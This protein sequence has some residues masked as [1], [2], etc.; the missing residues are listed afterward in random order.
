MKKTIRLHYEVRYL[1]NQLKKLSQQIKESTELEKGL[2]EAFEGNFVAIFSEIAHELKVLRL[3]LVL[4]LLANMDNANKR[5]AFL[6]MVEFIQ[7]EDLF[8]EFIDEQYDGIINTKKMK[9]VI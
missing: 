2:F 9:E 6:K 5:K 1:R 8:Q 4:L 7:Q 3:T